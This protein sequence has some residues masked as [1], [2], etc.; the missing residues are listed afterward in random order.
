MNKEDIKAHLEREAALAKM[1]E[2]VLKNEAYKNA[3]AI[4]KASIFD[5][6]CN[7]KRDQEEVRQEAW[8]TMKNLEALEDYFKEILETG[9]LSKDQLESLSK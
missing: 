6:F 2:Q 5:V 7:T 4:R 9:K 1:G 3:I 8:R